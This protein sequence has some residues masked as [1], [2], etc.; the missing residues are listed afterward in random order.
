V[1]PVASR[2]IFVPWHP[3]S[4]LDGHRDRHCACG[5]HLGVAS[6]KIYLDEKR[7]THL[8]VTAPNN[9][10]LVGTEWKLRDATQ[11]TF[12]NL[13]SCAAIFVVLVVAGLYSLVGRG[14]H[15]G[16]SADGFFLLNHG[17]VAYWLQYVT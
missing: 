2:G 17:Y 9:A 15:K 1:G 8:S 11:S 5:H 6:V 12:G 13:E 3:F 16:A 7:R 10:R 4:K 14:S